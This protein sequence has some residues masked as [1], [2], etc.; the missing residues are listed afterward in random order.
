VFVLRSAAAR[1]D[2]L[3]RQLSLGGAM[4]QN[5]LKNLPR[6]DQIVLGAGILAFIVSFF[7]FAGKTVGPYSYNYNAWNGLG[8]LGML[9]VLLGLVAVAWQTFGEQLPELPVSMTFVAAAASTLGALFLVIK[10]LTAHISVGG[11]SADLDVRVGGI[12]LAIAAVV[13]A[14][15]AVMRLRSSGESMPWQHAAEPPAA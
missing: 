12:L 3:S 6:N 7:H 15:F 13:Q 4:D 1:S 2:D 10:L 8:V 11:A 9:L 5:D 14:V